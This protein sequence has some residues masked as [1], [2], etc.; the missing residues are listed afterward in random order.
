MSLVRSPSSRAISVWSFSSRFAWRSS[1]C[2]LTESISRAR[3]WISER[4]L[5]SSLV[6][7][8]SSSHAILSLTGSGTH[9]FTHSIKARPSWI[10]LPQNLPEA[11]PPTAFPVF[12]RAASFIFPSLLSVSHL[13]SS[14]IPSAENGI[15][16]DIFVFI[17]LNAFSASLHPVANSASVNTAFHPA[18]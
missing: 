5:F 15:F 18:T 16:F 8:A 17:S 9:F 2:F 3:F 14:I 6:S 11:V 12:L 1:I 13:Y 4:T 7:N 10:A